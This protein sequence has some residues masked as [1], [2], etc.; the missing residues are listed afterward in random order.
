[1]SSQVLADN[2]R[3]DKIAALV[4][5]FNVTEWRGGRVRVAQREP[6]EPSRVSPPDKDPHRDVLARVLLPS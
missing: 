3:E 5:F 2:T 4:S 6:A 1:M